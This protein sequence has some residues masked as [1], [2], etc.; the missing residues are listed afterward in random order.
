M[1]YMRY[2][3]SQ[4][5][6]TEK[7]AYDALVDAISRREDQVKLPR[8]DND[9]LGRVYTAVDYDYPDFFYVDF[10]YYNGYVRILDTV[11]NVKY[12]M[13]TSEAKKYK[14]EIDNIAKKI[15][16]GATGMSDLEKVTYLNDEI[17]KLAVYDRNPNNEFNAQHLIG[18]FL[19][20]KC[21]CEGFAKSF[22]YLADMLELKCI[23]VV[24]DSGVRG[25]NERHA[26]NMVQ[27]DGESYYIDV[28]YNDVYRDK[29]TGKILHFSR[30]YFNLSDREIRRDHLPDTMFALPACPKS[31]SQIPIVSCTNDLISG[32]R[33][34]YAKK[35]KF[36]EIRVTKKFEIDE[37]VKLIENNMST[38]DRQWYY[39]IKMYYLSDYTFAIEWK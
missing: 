34:G 36:T 6:D 12:T 23:L 29:K 16:A 18:T 38:S 22:K 1:P 15:V 24:G 11:V 13:S 31:M 39:Q 19:D 20:G 3:R 10:Y 30:A 25:K 5:N 4:L 32:I 33:H 27:I 35:E 9:Q 7:K 14:R 8:I 21:V 2:Y 17:R 37:I 26:W 28:T